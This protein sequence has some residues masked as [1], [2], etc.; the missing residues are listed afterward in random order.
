MGGLIAAYSPLSCEH[1][2]RAVGLQEGKAGN[3]EAGHLNLGSGRIVQ[4][5]DVRHG[6]RMKDGSFEKNEVFLR[7]IA[8]VKNVERPCTFG[9]AHQKVFARLH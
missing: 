3:S 9:T 2:E 5:D 7:T 8:D 4:Q 6:R 1:P